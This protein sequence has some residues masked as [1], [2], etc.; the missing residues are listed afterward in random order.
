MKPE[1]S[2]PTHRASKYLAACLAAL[3][4][5]SGPG[6]SAA[7][8]SDALKKLQEEN[9]ALRKRLAEIE[10]RSAAP[11]PAAAP[12]AQPSTPAPA[13]TPAAS[14]ASA[15]PTITSTVGANGEEMMVLS[16]FQVTS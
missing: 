3:V 15:T 8:D 10:G 16:P 13:S 4:T 1:P 6:L 11:A 2:I 14:G 7:E 5:V 9:A 12:S